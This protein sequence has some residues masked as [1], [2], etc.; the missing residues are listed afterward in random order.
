MEKLKARNR[1]CTSSTRCW[2]TG[3]C[4]LGIT[5]P[6]ISEM[7]VQ[8]IMEAAC[9]VV[10][11]KI[12]AV[13]EIMIPLIADVNELRVMREMTVRIAEEVQKRTNV[14]VRYEWGP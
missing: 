13:P 14:R 3:D 5:Y 1:C 7:Q 12:K 4:R 8:A 10:K 9:H 2:G 6:E 11:R